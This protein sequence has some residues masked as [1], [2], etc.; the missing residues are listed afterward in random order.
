MNKNTKNYTYF[1]SKKNHDFLNY[2]CL[3]CLNSSVYCQ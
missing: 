3:L 2:R 1:I